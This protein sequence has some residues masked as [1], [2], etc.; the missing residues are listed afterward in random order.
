[1]FVWFRKGALSRNSRLSTILQTR[2]TVTDKR[3]EQY[4]ESYIPNMSSRP[5]KNKGSEANMLVSESGIPG[6]GYKDHES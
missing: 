5:R 3:E 2:T 4:G 6:K 1:M